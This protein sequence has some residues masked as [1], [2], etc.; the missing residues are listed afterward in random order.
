MFR[1]NFILLRNFKNDYEQFSSVELKNNNKIIND[2]ILK[3]LTLS[4]LIVIFFLFGKNTFIKLGFEDFDDNNDL[5]LNDYGNIMK[6]Y[7]LY[8]LYKYD[9]ITLLINGIMNWN[10]NEES[11]LN[12]INNLNQQTLED[13][14]IIFIIP[15]DKK[16]DFIKKKIIK[17]KK[18]KIFSPKN[19]LESDTFYLINMIKGKFI[20][21]LEKLVMFA[22]DEL[23]N[24]FSLTKGKID[25]V[26]ESQIQ[27]NSFYLIKTKTLRKLID[28][29]QFFENYSNLVNNITLLQKPQ[30]NY[31]SI[32]MCPNN[33]YVPLTYVSMISIL[34]SKEEF[35]FISFYLIISKDFKKQNFDLLLSL[36]EQFDYFN[37]TFVDM[38]DRYNNAFISKRMT[39]QTYFRFSL[40][41]FFP[42]LKRI[43]YLDSDIIVYKDLNKFY[44]LNFNGK[45]VLGQVTGCNNSKKTGI[46]HINNGILLFNLVQMRRMKIEEK[47]LGIIKKKKRFRYHDQTLMN[48]YFNKHIGIFPLEY[49]IRNWGN[50][51]EMKDWNRI[52][53]NVYNFDYFYFSQKYPSIRHF[54]GPVKPIKFEIN[55]IEDWWFFAR[56]SKYYK[57]KSFK[58][59]EIFSFNKLV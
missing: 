36:Y 14:Q 38:D 6:N 59:D 29:G 49:H 16:Y 57:R 30:L 9:Q 52:S 33:D 11:L 4:L 5:K 21:I 50:I 41:E 13:L 37:L 51:K 31:I 28:E 32:A 20:M 55:H 2:N 8:P 19:N 15:K 18:M 39:I 48:N 26:F 35:T 56:R 44:N 40:G 43:L 34:S 47:V 25:N 53:G 3:L 54:L 58:S 1:N 22:K 42:F 46:Y 24:F 7:S 17:N 27:N 12:F 45:M 23:E 10:I